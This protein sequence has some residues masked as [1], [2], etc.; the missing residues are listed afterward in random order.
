VDLVTAAIGL[1]EL[2]RTETYGAG[3]E[4]ELRLLADRRRGILVGATAVGPLASE[5]IHLPVLAIRAEVAV[6]VLRDTIPQFPTF[7]EGWQKALERLEL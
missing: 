4:G 2:A 1:D 5:F 7:S 3:F 6:S